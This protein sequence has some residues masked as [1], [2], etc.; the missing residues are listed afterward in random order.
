MEHA[1]RFKYICRL[2]AEGM[3]EMALMTLET[4]M[5]DLSRGIAVDRHGNPKSSMGR[6]P[7]ALS[8]AGGK[9]VSICLI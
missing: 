6:E 9:E 3:I 5:R 2:V 1:L 7:A 4:A 8:D